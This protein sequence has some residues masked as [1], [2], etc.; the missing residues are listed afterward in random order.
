MATSTDLLSPSVP[1]AFH[2]SQSFSES[3]FGKI[4][5]ITSPTKFGALG[6]IPSCRI[7]H[8]CRQCPRKRRKI[9]LAGRDTWP[10]SNLPRAER[11]CP[12]RETANIGTVPQASCVDSTIPNWI[13]WVFTNFNIR[14]E[15]RWLIKSKCIVGPSAVVNNIVLYQSS[16][17]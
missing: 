9:C 3:T 12:S 17:N 5:H 11:F 13:C 14:A 2:I 8:S 1:R 16:S 15:M 10:R 7:G 4:K 6:N